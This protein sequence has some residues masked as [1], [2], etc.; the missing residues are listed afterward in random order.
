MNNREVFRKELL[1]L[2]FKL[3]TTKELALKEE[4]NKQIDDVKKS[5]SKMLLEEIEIEHRKGRL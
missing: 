5:Y 2:R 4:I 3:M 1:E